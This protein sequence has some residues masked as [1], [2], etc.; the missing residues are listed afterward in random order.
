MGKVDLSAMSADQ[1]WSL[2]ERVS[3]ILTEKISSEK[4]R[5]EERLRKIGSASNTN[6]IRRSRRPYP[7]V[8]PK[9][10]NPKNR[11]ETWAGRGKQPRW[12]VALLRSGKKLEDFRI[13]RHR[14]HQ[15][16]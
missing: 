10:Q 6:S 5:L 2:H 16:G 3:S 15:S 11:S 14:A 4:A 13:K 8:L 9:Y 12:L 7:K 1:L